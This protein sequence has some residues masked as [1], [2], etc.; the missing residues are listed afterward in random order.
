MVKCLVVDDE[1]LAR[2]VLERYIGQL[3]NLLLVRGCANAMEAFETISNT[4]VDLMFLDVKMPLISGIDFVKNLKKPPPVI[5][6]T[7]FSEFAVRS[8]ELE[9][10]DYLLKPITF[11]RFEKSINKFLKQATRIETAPAFTYF[12]VDGRLVRIE[13]E[14]LVY[15]QSIRDYVI[16][17]TTRGN[18]ITHMT[19]KYLA[20]LLPETSFIRVHRS[21]L[22]GVAHITGLDNHQV[23]LDVTSIPIGDSFRK[24]LFMLRNRLIKS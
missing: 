24:K 21:Y 3:E 5:F 16:I 1:P 18:Y 11:D 9:A 6:T 4:N 10:V 13:H 8:Y 7:A 22:I 19:M 15:A 23:R 14:T 20:G 12:K 2:K 17:H